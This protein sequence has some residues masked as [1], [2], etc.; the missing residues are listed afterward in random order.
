MNK[1][2]AL[3]TGISGQSG[4]YLA[5]ILLEKDYDVFGTI[6]RHSTTE[7]QTKRIDHI[8]NDINLE[9]A[10]LTDNSSLER[11]IQLSKPDLIFNLAAQSHV[12]ISFDLPEHTAQTNCIG[13][14]NL[15]ENYRKF[16]PKAGFL[17][18][19][20][21]EMFGNNKDDDGFQ[22][23]TTP[24]SPV[25]PYGASKL[26]GFHLVSNYRRGYGLFACNSICFN[27][28][29]PRRGLNF[30]TNKIVKGAVEIKAGLKDKL[31]LGNLEAYRDWGHAKD[32]M[33]AAIMILEHSKPDDYVV[34]SGKC[35]SVRNFCE[36][37]FDN[38]GLD[39]KDYVV[40]DPRFMRPEELDYLKG[41][42][43]KIKETLGWKPDFSF[44]ALIE[45]MIKFW[46]EEIGLKPNKMVNK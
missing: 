6:R 32:Y 18:A 27:H 35:H 36:I 20:S 44:E 22:R 10:D 42:A 12:R 3:I 26:F 13:L 15:L 46:I 7:N 28:E 41:D 8:R 16:A 14:V 39:Y 43:T 9:Y 33:R 40:Q 25:S 11:I 24:M 34:A 5:E 45:D 37:T 4:S 1:K 2:V 31:E 23:E 21:S 30:V 29:S 38:L 17:Q 19:S